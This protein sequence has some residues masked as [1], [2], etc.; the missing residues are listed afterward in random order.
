LEDLDA[1]GII[2]NWI[3]SRMGQNRLDSSGSKVTGCCDLGDELP[4]F[5][6]CGVYHKLCKCQLLKDSALWSQ[7]MDPFL[8]QTNPNPVA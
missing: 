3:L 1:D 7:L 5:I 4:G 2:L 6:K 8:S